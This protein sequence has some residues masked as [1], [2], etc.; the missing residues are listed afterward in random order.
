MIENGQNMHKQTLF[1]YTRLYRFEHMKFNFGSSNRFFM[2][3]AVWVG[4]HNHF[5][6]SN[7]WWCEIM[8]LPV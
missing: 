4:I 7:D 1:Y 8:E 6:E 3:K 5:S 2:S